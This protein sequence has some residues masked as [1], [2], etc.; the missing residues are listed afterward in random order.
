[1]NILP[2]MMQVLSADQ[3]RQHG[4]ATDFNWDEA[5]PVYPCDLQPVEAS[6]Q[7]AMLQL[8]IQASGKLYWDSTQ[9]AIDDDARI[10]IDGEVYKLSTSSKVTLSQ[11]PGWSAKA[12]V[13]EARL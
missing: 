1:M 3:V 5:G 9:V 11:R 8:G 12:F 7:V 6:K 2:M 13:M 4:G 10:K